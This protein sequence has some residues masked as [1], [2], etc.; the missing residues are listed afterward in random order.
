MTKKLPRRILAVKLADTGDALFIV[1]ALRALRK[2]FPTARL[3]VLTT[4]AGKAGLEGLS[5]VDNTLVFNKYLFDTSRESL[6]PANLRKAA[7]FLL[8]LRLN[9]YDAVIFFHHYSLRWGVLKFKAVALATGAKLRAGLHDGTAYTN[10]L[11]IRVEDKGFGAD[12]MTERAYWRQLVTTFIKATTGQAPA[13][14]D[15]RPEIAIR[16]EDRTGAETL[17][18]E[19]RGEEAE[20][21]LIAFGPGSGGYTMTRR[22]MPARF[23]QIADC[24]VRQHGA[25]IAILGS[26]GE[27]ALADDIIRQADEK[28]SIVNMCGRTANVREAVSFL[29]GCDLFVGNDGG[30]AQMAGVAGVKSVVIFGPTNATAWAPY[31]SEA[32]EGEK[33]RVKIVQAAM[34]LPC[35]PCLYRGKSLGSRLG[36]AG[37]PCLTTISAE[38]VFETIEELLLS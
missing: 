2:A 14:Y 33:P 29:A 15:E 9:R 3:D 30:L 32:P 38:Q 37:R 8:Q 22:W 23:A 7:G 10:F 1:P 16:P 26:A 34:D 28:G 31:G 11:N 21:P 19:A 13:E 5:Y 6:A 36:C 12:G 17:L 25:R 24:L 20:R 27:K 18:K 4:E 35:R